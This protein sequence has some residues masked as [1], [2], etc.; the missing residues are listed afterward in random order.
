MQLTR[1]SEI[2]FRSTYMIFITLFL[3]LQN[4]HNIFSYSDKQ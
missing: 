4:L 1:D 3:L 2:E